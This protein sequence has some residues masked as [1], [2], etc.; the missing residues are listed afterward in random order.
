MRV[1]VRR[2]ALVATCA[3]PG[4]AYGQQ[5]PAVAP[6]PGARAPE[7][8]AEILSPPAMPAT[9]AALAGDVPASRFIGA[10]EIAQSAPLRAL[11]AD[12]RQLADLGPVGNHSGMWGVVAQKDHRRLAYYVTPDQAALLSGTAWSLDGHNLT[13]AAIAG[14]GSNTPPVRSLHD[15]AAPEGAPS[16]ESAPKDAVRPFRPEEVRRD[17]ALRA[18][19]ADGRSLLRLGELHGLLGVYALKG[20]HFQIYYLPPDRD[21]ILAGV[22]WN[23]QGNNLTLPQVRTIAGAI[24]TVT[25]GAFDAP[26]PGD[27]P[28]LTLSKAFGGSIGRVGAPHLWMVI[29]P[30]CGYSQQA[31]IAL[32]PFI[33]HGDLRLTIIP[34]ALNDYENG[35]AS[36]PAAQAL[37]SVPPPEVV[38]L[39]EKILDAGQ[40]DP[41][42]RRSD[43]APLR[44]IANMNAAHAIALKGTPTL[45]WK[46]PAGHEHSVMGVPHD[47]VTIL[48]DA[49]P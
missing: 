11:A 29:D 23:L 41:A 10:G 46:D 39:W 49:A 7:V 31:W 25:L 4:T 43:S 48:S 47:P 19:S 30:L 20:K 12:G 35:H 17:P 34:I 42:L 26:S 16:P 5:C 45:A 1:L 9:A 27:G 21:F 37:L 18:L 3:V 14:L 6:V 15:Q 22:M 2:I 13:E 40:A 32:K 44:L 36:T 28:A 24:P 8:P 38:P 33:D